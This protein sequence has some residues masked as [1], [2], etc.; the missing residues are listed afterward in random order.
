MVESKSTNKFMFYENFFWAI[1]KLP[2]E[3]RYK[4]CYDFC[5]YGITGELPKD[6]IMSMF[7][8][9]VSASVQKYQG[10]GGKREGAGRKPNK[11]KD[12]FENQKNQNNQNNQNNHK[13]Q[14]ETETKTKT[15]KYK[16]KG[17]VIKLNEKDFNDWEK[18]FPDLDLKYNLEKIDIWLSE[19]IKEKPEYKAKWFFMVQQMLLKNQNEVQNKNTYMG[20]G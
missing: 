6:E 7:C 9:G 8:I 10:R 14:T 12:L 11:N 18:K 19:K 15:E 3:K 5:K 13:T 2:E 17:N 16:Y 4:A 20:R 1:E